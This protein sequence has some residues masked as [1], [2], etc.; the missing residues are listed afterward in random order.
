[1]FEKFDGVKSFHKRDINS[2]RLSITKKSFSRKEVDLVSLNI[3]GGGKFLVGILIRR[4]T[5]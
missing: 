2:K 4:R 1:M 3:G 5:K